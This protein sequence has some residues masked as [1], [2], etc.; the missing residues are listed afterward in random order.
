MRDWRVPP[1]TR[2]AFAF[3]ALSIMLSAVLLGASM[4]AVPDSGAFDDDQMWR[5]AENRLLAAEALWVDDCPV[6]VGDADYGGDRLSYMFPTDDPTVRWV[7]DSY[8]KLYARSRELYRMWERS[9]HGQDLHGLTRAIDE[10]CSWITS[11]GTYCAWE[12]VFN[13]TTVH[14]G[15]DT[16]SEPDLVPMT[17]WTVSHDYSGKVVWSNKGG[18]V[19]FHAKLVLHLWYETER[20]QF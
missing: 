13:G 1:R 6:S 16:V 4:E 19:P 3:L 11:D 15:S 14:F 17:S 18:T 7:V 10:K 2:Y 9:Y 5:V 8:F 20:P 12:L